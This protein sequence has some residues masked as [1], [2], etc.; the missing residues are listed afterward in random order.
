VT[1]TVELHDLRVPGRHGVEEH[2]RTRDRD[3]LYDVSFDVSDA[4]LSDRVEDAVDYRDVAQCIR[5][6][7]DGRSY[8]LIEALA[9]AVADAI[10]ARFPV[11]WVRVRVRKPNLELAGLQLGEAVAVVERASG[12]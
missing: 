1:F 12:R 5:D 3:F 6:V 2:E 11:E 7:S 9:A 4:A 8:H 10:V